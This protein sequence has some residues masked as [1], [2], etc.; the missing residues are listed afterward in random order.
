[1]NKQANSTSFYDQS[2]EKVLERLKVDQQK[3][4]SEREVNVRY[5]QHG[6]NRI[7]EAKRRGS[8]KGV[9]CWIRMI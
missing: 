7:H 6:P 8:W 3:G 9:N 2:A 1:M 5:E 4:L